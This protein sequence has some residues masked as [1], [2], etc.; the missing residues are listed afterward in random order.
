MNDLPANCAI[1]RKSELQRFSLLGPEVPGVQ[2][3]TPGSDLL[4]DLRASVA[5]QKSSKNS[6]PHVKSG[7]RPSVEIKAHQKLE[8][9]P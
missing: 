6:P 5:V 2:V 8:S 1:A 4:S 9:E 3:G 7:P